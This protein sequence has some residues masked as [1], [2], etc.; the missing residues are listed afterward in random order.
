MEVENTTLAPYEALDREAVSLNYV[1]EIIMDK[2]KVER[3]P[4]AVTFCEDTPPE[5]YELL[6]EPACTLI[7]E[8]ASGRKVYVDSNNNACF[9]GLY[10]TGM[11]PGMDMIKDGSYL[12]M[13]Q[14]MFTAE[15]A[16]INKET[17]PNLPQGLYKAIAVAPLNEVPEG[18]AVHLMAVIC[19]PQRAMMISGAALAR[20][21]SL[22]FGEVGWSVC[23]SLYALPFH[24]RRSLFTIGDGGGRIHNSLKPSELFAVVPAKDMK[25]IIEMIENFAINSVDM[26]KEVMPGVYARMR[27]AGPPQGVS[28]PQ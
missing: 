21:G 19:D 24:N 2:M 16:R 8:G 17:T 9:V 22:P 10:H 27:H 15:G 25:Y 18:V 26:R 7:K 20:T 5:G 11:H 1:Y 28:Q 3:R 4:V 23:S 6:N 13:S 12:T 14:G